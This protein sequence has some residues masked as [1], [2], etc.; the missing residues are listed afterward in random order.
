MSWNFWNFILGTQV[1][2]KTYKLHQIVYVI[3]AMRKFSLYNLLIHVLD[4]LC[5][6]RDHYGYVTIQCEESKL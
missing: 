2:K 6:I 4:M 3:Q 1:I 5:F